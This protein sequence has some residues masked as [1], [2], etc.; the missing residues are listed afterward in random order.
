[1]FLEGFS[2]FGLCDG[3]SGKMGVGRVGCLCHMTL[4]AFVPDLGNGGVRTWEIREGQTG[5]GN[6][7]PCSEPGS[8]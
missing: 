6:G 5:S 7:E 4:V 1:M 2:I 3:L 8:S